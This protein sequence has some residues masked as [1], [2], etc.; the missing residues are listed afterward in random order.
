MIARCVSRRPLCGEAERERH[1]HRRVEARADGRH[2]QLDL[3]E[4][5]DEGGGDASGHVSWRIG[6]LRG[7][8][9]I[10]TTVTA[11]TIAAAGVTASAHRPAL[12]IARPAAPSKAVASTATKRTTCS[13]PE[14]R[15]LPRTAPSAAPIMIR[16][17]ISQQGPRS[18]VFPSVWLCARSALCPRTFQAISPGRPYVVTRRVSSIPSGRRQQA[19]RHP[20]WRWLL[21]I[22]VATASEDQADRHVASRPAPRRLRRTRGWRN[23]AHACRR[24]GGT[25]RLRKCTG[26]A[27]TAPVR[28][29]PLAANALP[30]PASAIV[31]MRASKGPRLA[32]AARGCDGLQ[33]EKKNPQ[34]GGTQPR[35]RP[36]RARRV[37]FSACRSVSGQTVA[38]YPVKNSQLPNVLFARNN[39]A[40]GSRRGGRVPA[41]VGTRIDRGSDACGDHRRHQA[42]DGRVIRRDHDHRPQDREQRQLSGHV[43]QSAR[44]VSSRHANAGPS[45]RAVDTSRATAAH[46]AQISTTRD[47]PSSVRRRCQVAAGD[48]ASAPHDA[49]AAAQRNAALCGSKGLFENGS[50]RTGQVAITR[51]TAPSSGGRGR[52]RRFPCESRVFGSWSLSV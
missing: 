8:H 39:H 19:Y 16:S 12:Q 29:Q 26:P 40:E 43:P 24:D 13:R 33:S 7:C 36:M 38:T 5:H 27:R 35:S 17:S 37:W 41:P 42:I 14:S 45:L 44:T 51:R 21:L 30:T 32:A 23:R 47:Q 20:P 1:R 31:T 3:D 52:F 9:A 2:T 48:A 49:A 22:P 15:A 11:S 28:P 34:T 6:P 50:I 4:V 18:Q 10:H 46:A 25:P